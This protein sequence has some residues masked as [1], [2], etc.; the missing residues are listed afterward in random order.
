MASVVLTAEVRFGSKEEVV[1]VVLFA[2]VGNDG[3]CRARKVPMMESV[4][5]L[6]K[7]RR[8]ME[9]IWRMTWRVKVRVGG[10]AIGW[11]GSGQFESESGARA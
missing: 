9:S 1:L 11:L 8:E 2:E 5:I 6:W 10:L 3:G 4:D 7:A